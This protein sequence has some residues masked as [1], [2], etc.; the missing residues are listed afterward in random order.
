V[1][2]L[3][4]VYLR[5]I[6]EETFLIYTITLEVADSDR[7]T[8]SSLYNVCSAIGDTAVG[9]WFSS[10]RCSSIRVNIKVLGNSVL[11]LNIATRVQRARNEICDL[12]TIGGGFRIWLL[13]TTHRIGDRSRKWRVALTQTHLG[14][15]KEKFTSIPAPRVFV[16]TLNLIA[17]ETE[18]GGKIIAI[19]VGLNLIC[20]V[21]A[22]RSRAG[23]KIWKGAAR[24]TYMLFRSQIRAEV[25]CGVVLGEVSR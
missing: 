9:T 10:T 20:V 13:W 3:S 23:T 25:G 17:C 5:S 15:D 22:V 24:A 11:A 8:P 2:I 21:C 1:S 19:V 7:T 12:G 6:L 4:Y 16:E 14:S 18:C